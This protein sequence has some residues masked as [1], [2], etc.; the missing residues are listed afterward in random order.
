[1]GLLLL[2]LLLFPPCTCRQV[3]DAEC[4]VSPGCVFVDLEGLR[5]DG[6]PWA[7]VTEVR[8]L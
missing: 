4:P 2:F 1:M 7:G 5:A 3:L 8:G 6:S